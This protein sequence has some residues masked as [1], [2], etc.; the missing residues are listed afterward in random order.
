M[1]EEMTA[2]ATSVLK[3]R[4]ESL[5]HLVRLEIN[6]TYNRCKIKITGKTIILQG[7]AMLLYYRRAGILWLEDLCTCLCVKW[8]NMERAMTHIS[9]WVSKWEIYYYDYCWK[10]KR[11]N[12]GYHARLLF[13]FNLWNLILYCLEIK[14][15]L[16][17]IWILSY[18]ET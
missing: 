16:I 5:F 15:N 11:K 12:H 2:D 10:E 14:W 9:E 7:S 17:G 3:T 13:A 4:N 6:A 1:K 18:E 8:V